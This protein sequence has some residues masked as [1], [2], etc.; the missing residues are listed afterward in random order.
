[1]LTTSHRSDTV[2]MRAQPVRT[3]ALFGCAL[4]ALAVLAAVHLTQ[5]T[6]DVDAADILALLMGRSDEAAAVVV[7]SRMPRLIAGL[8]VGAALG[9]S[10]GIL[11]SVTRNS[12]ASPDTLA[13]NAGAYFALTLCAA[14]GI[15]LPLLSGAGVAFTGGIIAAGGVLALSAGAGG[16]PVRLVL[17]GS[18]IALGLAALTSILL[19]FFPWQTQG[20]FAWGAGSLNQAGLTGILTLLPIVVL[21]A[22]AF[23]VFGSQ[24][25]VLQLGDDAAAGLGV[26][27]RLWQT[28]FIVIA[29]LCAA[30]AV[31]AAGPIGFVGLC[32]PALARLC[33]RFV[34]VLSRQR[35]LVGVSALIGAGLVIGADVLM[36][37]IFGAVEGVSI[38][39]GVVTSL[40]GAVFLVVLAQTMRAGFDADSLVTMR[41]G[42]RLGLRRPWVLIGAAAG[43]LAAA[44][45]AS[46]LLGDT[47]LLGGDVVNWL[48]GVASTRIDIVLDARAP[49]IL[50]A[51]LGGA[52]L[53]LAG[54]IL[55]GVTRNPLADP[56]VLGISGA[57]ATGAVTVLVVAGSSDFR[58]VFAGALI[59]AICVGLALFALSIRG[60]LDHT[61]LTLAGVGIA[62]VSGALTTLMLVRTNPWNQTLAMTWLGG[63]TYGATFSQCIPMVIALIAA[64]GVLAACSRDLDVLQTDELTPRLLGIR[65]SG[66]R[67]ALVACA[68]VLT[69]AATVTIG[70]I[71]FVGLVAPHAARI[72]IGRT[73]SRLFPLAAIGG[74]LLV[75]VADAVG[76][77]VIA[78]GQIP[79][80]LITALLGCPYFVW[81]LWRM[82]TT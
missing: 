67:I 74:G 3:A 48:K 50:A 77:T 41:A 61:R 8:A 20:L 29:V 34:P 76:R 52:C 6:S 35:L 21:A 58:T 37:A 59:A 4:I 64:A 30:V 17:G 36:R 12:L 71:A 28:I 7:D 40:V 65:V 23:T 56:S 47:M 49:R 10:G 78:P 13:V 2:M 14:F 66:T 43:L 25:D 45:A 15:T 70:T 82:R 38:P 72:V 81:L 53:A 75:T 62:A 31:T 60:G 51:V 27:V 73:H 9:M 11:Q 69:A 1:M 24:L 46:M 63:S 32:A 33:R 42:T 54:T 19:L 39:T 18:V 80:G 57:A 5:G 68:L 22:A 55:Q 26:R 16:S 44:S 79:A